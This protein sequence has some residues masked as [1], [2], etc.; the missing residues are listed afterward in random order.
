MLDYAD[1]EVIVI[2][3]A[4]QDTTQDVISANKDIITIAV[5]EKDTGIYNAMNKGIKRVTGDY[6]VF[7]NAG[8]LFANKDVLHW[9]NDATGDIILG[10]ES[11]GGKIR[12]VKEKMTL[13]DLLSIG[14]NHQAVYYRR[15][16]LQKYGFDESYKLIADLKSVVEP[17]VKDQ[18]T[19][20]CITK[21]L[22][23]CEGGGVSQQR[24]RDTITENR[25]LVNEVMD[26][27]HKDDYVRFAR[28][29]NDMIDDF[30][31]LSYFR[32]LFPILRLLSRIAK[33]IN[34]HFKH[35]PI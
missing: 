3:G 30:I 7:M 27:F 29:N 28:I 1:K 24:W 13:Y 11:Y 23:I 5:S 4:S 2:D 35:I 32:S 8:D 21:I 12:M 25:R 26:P 15:E 6:V 14:L 20:T 9:V 31:T 22:A 18:V 10:G 16:I 33:I 34:K 19:V 17:L